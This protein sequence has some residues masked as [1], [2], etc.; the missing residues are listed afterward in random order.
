[1][2]SKWVLFVGIL[3]LTIGILLRIFT[4]KVFA[5]IILIIIGVLIKT[6][7]IIDKARSG[8]YKPGYELVFLFVGL[9]LFLS[10]IYLRYN[11][12]TFNPSFL[13]VSGITLKLVFVILFIVNIRKQ[14]NVTV[15]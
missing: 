12:P 6:Y 1:M 15:V 2:K 4:D 9:L 8:V 14:R 13:I 7:Y 5:A 11:K 10:G 3:L